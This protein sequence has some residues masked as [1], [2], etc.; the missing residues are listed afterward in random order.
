MSY[1]NTT[2]ESGETLEKS[3]RKANKQEILIMG[4]FRNHPSGPWAP[5][6]VHKHVFDEKTPLTSVRRAMTDLT[7]DDLLIKTDAQVMGPYGKN[8]HTWKLAP[9]GLEQL[10][11]F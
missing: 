5:H 7:D 2:G 3:R 10:E 4:F 11:M 8:V 1:F 9:E 6:I